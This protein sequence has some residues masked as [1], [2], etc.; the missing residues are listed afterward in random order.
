MRWL[1]SFLDRLRIVSLDHFLHF[2]LTKYFLSVLSHS[3]HASLHNS[4]SL[5]GAQWKAFMMLKCL[6]QISLY[7]M[8]WRAIRN[9]K[10][11][12]ISKIQKDSTRIN[13]QE[14][15]Q[16]KSWR[17]LIKWFGERLQRRGWREEKRGKW[18]IKRGRW[19]TERE[20]GRAR[21]QAKKSLARPFYFETNGQCQDHCS[22]L[23]SVLS[24]ASLTYKWFSPICAI[25]I[26][27]KPKTKKNNKVK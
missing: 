24:G 20:N 7:H 9:R 16:E 5:A 2:S 23:N 21:K 15:K 25:H 1:F 4:A 6:W 10:A 19:K 22:A 12:Q 27:R 8:Q 13:H 18:K 17:Q 14:T 26:F 11:K 3:C